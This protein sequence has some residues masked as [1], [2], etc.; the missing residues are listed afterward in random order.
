MFFGHSRRV[1]DIERSRFRASQLDNAVLWPDF[2][3]VWPRRRGLHRVAGA[4]RRAVPDMGLADPDD[5]HADPAHSGVTLTIAHHALLAGNRARTILFMW[6]TVALG[7]IFLGAQVYE[8]IHAYRDLNLKLS[9]GPYGSTFF[10]LTGSTAFTSSWHADAA[11]HHPSADAR[12]FHPE[13]HFASKGPR[14]TGTSS[15]WSG[16]VSTSSSTGCSKPRRAGGLR[17]RPRVL[18]SAAACPCR[19]RQRP[20]PDR[21]AGSLARQRPI[22]TPVGCI[23]PS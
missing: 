13:R 18:S 15:T 16:S 22:G 3:A 19:R 20:I 2:K 11:I 10:M 7:I 6:V 14:G 8:Y 23:Q 4:D 9:S 1:V 5:Q 12:T 21:S 17:S